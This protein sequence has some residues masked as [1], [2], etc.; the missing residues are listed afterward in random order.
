MEEPISVT[1]ALYELRGEIKV[2][3][4]QLQNLSSD[5]ATLKAQSEDRRNSMDSLA[6][7]IRSEIKCSE[8]ATT[9]QI[10]E[11]NTN[12]TELKTQ[13]NVGKWVIAALA[14]TVIALVGSKFWTIVTTDFSN[15]EHHNQQS[16]V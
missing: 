3:F 14:T 1:T 7:A 10:I 4:N 5:I 15:F 2:V 13:F 9:K 16:K 12:Y 8:D 11:I 6:K